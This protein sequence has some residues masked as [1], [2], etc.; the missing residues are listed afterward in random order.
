MKLWKAEIGFKRLIKRTNIF[1][2][3]KK[4]KNYETGWIW[5]EFMKRGM[6]NKVFKDN[7]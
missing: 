2:K 4:I 5:I 7:K 3:L 1:W 6:T